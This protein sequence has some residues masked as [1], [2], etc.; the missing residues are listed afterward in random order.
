MTGFIESYGYESGEWSDQE[1]G[2]WDSL[3]AGHPDAF[4]SEELQLI[5][6]E[7][8]FDTAMWSNDNAAIREDMEAALIQYL[9]QYDIDFNE[10]FD[11]DAYREWYDSQV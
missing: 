6:H 11:Y 5:F 2:I 8:M 9:E 7:A 10:S 1:R 4:Q 3:T